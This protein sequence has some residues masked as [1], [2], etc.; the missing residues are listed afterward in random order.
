MSFHAQDI[1]VRICRAVKAFG[2]ALPEVGQS[3]EVERWLDISKALTLRNHWGMAAA[4][5]E[6]ADGLHFLDL[7]MEGPPGS[8]RR[9]DG[10]AMADIWFARASV[11][12]RAAS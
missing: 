2:Y 12:L 3:T 8:D 6:Y 5:R 1:T 11:Y 9:I 7:A 10:I 4:V